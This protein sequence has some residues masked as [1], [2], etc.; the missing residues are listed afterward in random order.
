MDYSDIFKLDDSVSGLPLKFFTNSTPPPLITIVF[1]VINSIILFIGFVGNFLVL[2]IYL[3]AVIARIKHGH[4]NKSCFNLQK[5]L[6][7]P[8]VPINSSNSM[9]IVNMAVSDFLFNLTLPIKIYNSW[10]LQFPM[11]IIA[12]KILVG[13]IPYVNFLVTSWFTTVLSIDNFLAIR[14]QKT[15]VHRTFKNSLLVSICIWIFGSLLNLPSFV[16]YDKIGDQCKIPTNYSPDSKNCQHDNSN[17]NFILWQ[18]IHVLYAFVVP[19]A[20]LLVM[21]SIALRKIRKRGETIRGNPREMTKMIFLFVFTYFLCYTPYFVWNFVLLFGVN[22]PIKTC[23]MIT[24]TTQS[25][26]FL[27]AA[28]N[29]LLYGLMSSSFQTRIRLSAYTLKHKQVET[30]EGMEMLPTRLNMRKLSVFATDP[31]SF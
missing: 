27:K 30:E 7:I 31:S 28:L 17:G 29:P 18:Y 25:L 24:K 14:D 13:Y 12:C 19:S 16:F 23:S 6:C 9:Y 10:T 2:Y 8:M 26:V 4:A 20:I 21:Y 5:F 22:F 15:D 1:T 3:P 11:E